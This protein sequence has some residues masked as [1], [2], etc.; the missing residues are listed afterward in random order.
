M[1]TDRINIPVACPVCEEPVELPTSSRY[2][3]SQQVVTINSRPLVDHVRDQHAVTISL[4]DVCRQPE[5]LA[6][7]DPGTDQARQ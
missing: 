2:E 6:A 7:G 5:R 4:D 3:P 1:A